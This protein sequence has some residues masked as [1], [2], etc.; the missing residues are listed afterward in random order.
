MTSIAI[1]PLIL[2]MAPADAGTSTRA[3]QPT[4]GSAGLGDRLYPTLGNGGYDALH[5]NLDLR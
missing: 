3:G 5:Y 2:S 4:P 1:L